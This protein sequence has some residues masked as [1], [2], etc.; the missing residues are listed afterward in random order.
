MSCHRW[1]TW[2]CST[3]IALLTLALVL[4]R[5]HAAAFTTDRGKLYPLA[6]KWQYRQRF[7]S[8]YVI[9]RRGKW[10][11]LYKIEVLNQP[12]DTSC[13]SH[14]KVL[15]ESH[16]S[17]WRASAALWY[18]VYF[19][20]ALQCSCFFC[21]VFLPVHLISLVFLTKTALNDREKKI[22]LLRRKIN[23]QAHLAFTLTSSSWGFCGAACEVTPWCLE[24]LFCNFKA[25]GPPYSQNHRETTLVYRC[26]S[27]CERIPLEA[28]LEMICRY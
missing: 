20:L 1:A 14:V 2:H 23:E 12:A 27:C 28:G 11:L 7:S 21:F 16:H 18:S 19:A 15:P 9:L 24:C 17:H 25:G 5:S 26:V 3:E 4:G 13:S 6:V 22:L 8:S 10:P